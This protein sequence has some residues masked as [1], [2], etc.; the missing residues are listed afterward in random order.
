MRIVVCVKHVPDI[1]SDRTLGADGRVVRDGG[2]GTL[3][4]L[5]ENAVEAALELAATDKGSEV[6]ALTVGP[7]DAE[8]AARRALQMGADAAVHVLDDAVAGSDVFAT[9]T[10]LAAAIRR[11]GAA[12]PVDLVVTGMAALDGLTSMLPV[13]LAAELD[14]PAL[15]L[16][17]EVAVDGGAVRV[18]RELDSASE[19]LSAPLP[20]LVSVTDQANEPRYPNFKGILAARKKRVEVLTLADL[21]VDPATVGTAGARTQVVGAA[22]RPVRENRVLVTDDGTAGLKLA[23]YLVERKLV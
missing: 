12:G 5:D 17:A 19:V 14:L 9:A 16:A 13:A 1:Q 22:A 23:A 4:E 15:T 2:D 6:V 10:V 20:A 3:N 7:P 21:G 8:D 18:R 11:V